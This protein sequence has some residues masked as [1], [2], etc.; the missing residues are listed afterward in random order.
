MYAIFF[1]IKHNKHI[2]N[3]VDGNTYYHRWKKADIQGRKPG[4]NE[5]PPRNVMVSARAVNYHNNNES[6]LYS[7]ILADILLSVAELNCSVAS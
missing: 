7:P 1:S 5:V 4:D 3:S 6:K 2:K